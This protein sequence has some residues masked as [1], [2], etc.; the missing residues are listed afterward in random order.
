ML[1]L[2][3]V[4]ESELGGIKVYVRKYKN[5]CESSGDKVINHLSNF[6]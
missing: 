4:R 2:V 3:S 6:Y 5:I 1:I